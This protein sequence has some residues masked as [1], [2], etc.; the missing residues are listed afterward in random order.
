[1]PLFVFLLK[2]LSDHKLQRLETLLL[3]MAIYN[4]K[5]YVVAIPQQYLLAETH[6]YC[7]LLEA[8]LYLGKIEVFMWKTGKPSL[9][10]YYLV[11][12]PHYVQWWS[13]DALIIFPSPFAGH[14][15]SPVAAPP[16]DFNC[17]G[18]WPNVLT[19]PL[20]WTW[21]RLNEVYFSI[22]R[23]GWFMN[24]PWSWQDNSRF[25]LKDL[26]KILFIFIFRAARVHEVNFCFDV[27]VLSSRECD[28]LLFQH[29]KV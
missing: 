21:W 16:R 26:V 23:P 5:S 24:I 18:H 10:Y 4:I 22:L 7:N 2:G 27:S 6:I 15:C 8:L 29:V 19:A 1:M 25:Q 28:E 20:V 14:R 3:E 12:C 17:A 9:L 11:Q 13:D